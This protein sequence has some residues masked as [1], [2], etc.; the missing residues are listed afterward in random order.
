MEGTNRQTDRWTEIN[1]EPKRDR[2]SG[3]E[4]GKEC[5]PE[6][7]GHHWAYPALFHKFELEYL[8]H[9]QLCSKHW[10]TKTRKAVALCIK[11][12]MIT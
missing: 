11:D 5:L 7:G 12:L 1:R 3:R 4:D 8:P 6:E 10:G 2:G 9:A